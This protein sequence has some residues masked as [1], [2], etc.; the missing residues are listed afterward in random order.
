MYFIRTHDRIRI[1]TIIDIMITDRQT[2]PSKGLPGTPPTTEHTYAVPIFN[3]YTPLPPTISPLSSTQDIRLTLSPSHSS[4][5]AKTIT[6]EIRGDSPSHHQSLNTHVANQN[7]TFAHHITKPN[8]FS[9]YHR[10]HGLQTQ[11]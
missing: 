4:V 8:H 9:R 1:S 10:R 7:Q 5:V 3:P 11:L 6:S 2:T